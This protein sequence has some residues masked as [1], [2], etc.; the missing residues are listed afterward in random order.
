MALNLN[1]WVNYAKTRLDSA[2]GRGNE[3][4]DRLEAGR[5]AESADKPWLTSDGEAPTLDE[6][7]ARIEWETKHQADAASS[8][9][10]SGTTAPTGPD[11][12][13]AAAE[14]EQ[15]RLELDQRQKAAAERLSQIREELGVEAPP[16]P[17]S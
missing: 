5:A 4:L 8:G 3:E 9:R 2:I 15:A 7:R 1:Q 12:V 13:R 17:E 11:E 6:A 14:A 10:A 16:A